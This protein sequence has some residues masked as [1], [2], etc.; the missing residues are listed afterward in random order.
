MG[1]WH[2]SS[3]Q[4]LLDDGDRGTLCSLRAL[5]TACMK[6]VATASCR[7]ERTTFFLFDCPPE[8]G[9]RQSATKR[10]ALLHAAQASR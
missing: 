5:V 4:D 3:R 6:K 1:P 7:R 9:C 2:L 10:L 8:R